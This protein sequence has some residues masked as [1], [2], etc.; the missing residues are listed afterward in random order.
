SKIAQAQ[1]RQAAIYARVNTWSQA[2]STGTYTSS[3][4]AEQLDIDLD[5]ESEYLI[6]NDRIFALFERIGGRMTNAWLRDFDTGYV[7][8]VVGNPVSYA[9]SETEEEGSGNFSSGAVNAYRTSG[10]KDWFAK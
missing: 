10:F 1:T 6:Y 5:G 4:V 2:A 8:Q 7:S 9:G 3:A